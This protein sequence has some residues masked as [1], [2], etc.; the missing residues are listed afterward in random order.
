MKKILISMAL[1]SGLAFNSA[2]AQSFGDDLFAS[3]ANGNNS[4]W[5]DAPSYV[6]PRDVIDLDKLNSGGYD[7]PETGYSGAAGYNKWTESDSTDAQA[8]ID[9]F[10]NGD[11]EAVAGAIGD[12]MLDAAYVNAIDDAMLDVAYVNAIDDAMW[13]NPIAAGDNTPLWG[14][15]SGDRSDGA[16]TY[17]EQTNFSTAE[18]SNN[19]VP[20]LPAGVR[21]VPH[22][23]VLDNNI[24]PAMGTVAYCQDDMCAISKDGY[25]IRSYGGLRGDHSIDIVN[26]PFDENELEVYIDGAYVDKFTIMGL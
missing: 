3:P 20:V 14:E 13:G 5:N 18:R 17:G 15:G 12:A 1:L 8:N 11:D 6:D 2:S 16:G 9:F 10:S 25:L 22:S 19:A 7:V 26:S 24:Q 4:S 21:I 23:G